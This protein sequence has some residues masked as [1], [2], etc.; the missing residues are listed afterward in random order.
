M[1]MG[2][3]SVIL[4]SY[5]VCLRFESRQQQKRKIA[6]FRVI[7]YIRWEFQFF[8]E[9][10]LG[11]VSQVQRYNNNGVSVCTVIALFYFSVGG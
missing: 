6:F 5:F 3:L 9:A 1:I 7:F 4:G 2:D 10:L 11:T 8:F